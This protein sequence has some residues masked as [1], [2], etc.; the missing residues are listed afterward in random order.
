MDSWASNYYYRRNLLRTRFPGIE[1]NYSI[2]FRLILESVCAQVH[3]GIG[4][5]KMRIEYWK[6]C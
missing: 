4:C 5:E 6:L 3:S 2:T 1:I